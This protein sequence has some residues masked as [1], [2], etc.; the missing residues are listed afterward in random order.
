MSRENAKPG[1][2]KYTGYN[3]R[4]TI[5]E[6]YFQ[7]PKEGYKVGQEILIENHCAYTGTFL[8]DIIDKVEVSYYFNET[9]IYRCWVKGGGGWLQPLVHTSL[10]DSIISSVP[11]NNFLIKWNKEHNY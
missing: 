11:E 7:Y 9:P 5:H 1:F 6:G 8:T 3:S 2:H 4:G 10:Y